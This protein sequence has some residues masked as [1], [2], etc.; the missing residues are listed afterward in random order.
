MSSNIRNFSIVAH[1][2]HGKST[3]ADRLLEH[4][5]TIEKRL[6]KEQIL[7]SMDLERERGVTIKAKAIRIDYKGYILNLIDTPGHVDFGY[8]VSRALAA[9]EGALLVVDA[10]QGIEA[11][12][13]A[14]AY[15]AINNNLKIIPV[16]NKIDLP[17]A[18]PKMVAQELNHV[19]GI[20][21]TEIVHASA[22]S[23]IGIE[24]VLNAI[25][26]RVP[27]PSGDLD[28][29][30]QALIF[31]SHYDIYRG[32]V[33]YT[34]IVNGK[35]SAGEKIRMMR[36][37][38]EFE[39]LETGI[40]KLNLVPAQSL[41]AGEV[42]YIIANI[43]DVRDAHVGDTITS[44]NNPAKEALPG[45]KKAKPMVFCGLY[46]IDGDEYSCLKDAL[47]KLSLND[48][49]LFF[50]PETSLAL[51]FGF[52]CG[53]LGLLHFEIVQE[54]LERE[55]KLS[56]IATAPNVVYKI[57]LNDKKNIYIDNPSKMPDMSRVD[58]IEEPYYK[59]TVLCPERYVG[60]IMTLSS[61]KRG[62]FINMEYLD[63]SHV[64]L[65]YQFPLAEIVT[66]FYDMLKSVSQGYA[67]MDYEF[68]GYKEADLV[69]L[70]ILINDEPVDALSVI[71]L[72]QNAHY[73]GRKIVEKLRGVI[74][75][76][77]FEVPVQAAIGSKIIA[78]E[79]I[80]AM[81][82]NVL[83]KCYGGDVTR[84]RKL[85]EK[86]KKGKKRMKRVGK[87][88][89]PQEAFLSVLKIK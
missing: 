27:P 36:T 5:G 81:R 55:Y 43:K 6:M 15:L 64:M 20:E 9:C 59:V 73:H 45:Y 48:A 37:G 87:V 44:A 86:Q 89:I 61:E 35:I 76:Q 12:T 16:I 28:A 85:L 8:E 52:R 30:L 7:D 72:R 2:D 84:K 74:P 51:G 78:R 10:A 54:R 25:I 47:D 50:E 69:K 70:D 83:A 88:D 3:L 57:N 17:S 29:P 66:E 26:E 14:N 60:P 22:K 58:F 34:R 41:I 75:R 53:F 63:M 67:S 18:D 1:I 23:G 49:S 82:K 80:K 24:E 13:L 77:M 71:V 40:F 46:P 62:T 65:T 11:Q 56:L 4:T 68:L 39:V 21:E 19:F 33:I 79:N 38:T 42:G 31:D 32:V